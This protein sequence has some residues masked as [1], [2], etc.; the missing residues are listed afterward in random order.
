MLIAQLA[1]RLCKKKKESRGEKQ[2]NTKK[3][4]QT[5]ICNVIMYE[6]RR[7][8]NK[9]VRTNQQNNQTKSNT[10]S[11]MNNVFV[12]FRP[13]AKEKNILGW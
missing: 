11:R 3:E 4:H 5:Y 8:R 10:K 9:N 7:N 1:F 6:L 2:N 12:V 13:K